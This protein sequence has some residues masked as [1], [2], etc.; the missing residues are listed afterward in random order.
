MYNYDLPGR[1]GAVA[2]VSGCTNGLEIGA[3][4]GHMTR[5]LTGEGFGHLFTYGGPTIASSRHVA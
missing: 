3:G 4:L 1:F 5:E 2:G